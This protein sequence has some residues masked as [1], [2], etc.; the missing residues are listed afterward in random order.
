MK[1]H[2][3][4]YFLHHYGH[5]LQDFHHHGRVPHGHHGHALHDGRVCHGP[6]YAHESEII[7]AQYFLALH[8]NDGRLYLMTTT[9]FHH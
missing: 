3:Y 6:G 9:L 7:I 4:D 2:P 8:C 5:S 1:F